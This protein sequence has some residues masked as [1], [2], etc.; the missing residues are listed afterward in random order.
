MKKHLFFLFA[1]LVL[2]M[3]PGAMKAQTTVTIGDGTETTYMAPYYSLYNYSFV[4]QIYTAAEID[5]PTGGLIS[6]IGFYMTSLDNQPITMTVFMKNVSRST[7]DSDMDY[8][9]VDDAVVVYEGSYTFVP[10]WNIIELSTP[11]QYNGT[12]NLMIAFDEH[13]SW[14]SRYFT[15]T[16]VPDAVLCYRSDSEDPDPDDLASFSGSKSVSGGRP[17]L[18]ITFAPNPIVQIGSG[19]QTSVNLPTNVNFNYSLTEQIYMEE[20][21]GQAGDIYTIAF[22]NTT[23]IT[24]RNLNIYMILTNE[25][26]FNSGS[27][28]SAVPSGSLVYSGDVTFLSDTW[29]TIELNTP[30]HY[31]GSGNIMV[32]VDDNTGDEDYALY[33]KVFDATAPRAWYIFNDNTNYSPTSSGSGWRTTMNQKNQIRFGFTPVAC[34][35][36]THLAVS[37]IG[38]N[39]AGVSWEQP[40]SGNQWIVQCSTS[41]D[42]SAFSEVTIGS[43]SWYIYGLNPNTTY[44]VRVAN[45][46]GPEGIS[47]WSSMVSFSTTESPCIA[48]TDLTVSNISYDGAYLTWDQPDGGAEWLI[49][50]STDPEFSSSSFESTFD[51]YLSLTGLAPITTY[52]VRVA[53]DCGTMGISGWVTTSF[54]TTGGAIVVSDIIDFETNNLSQ[55]PFDNDATYPWIVVAVT[56]EC[57]NCG[58]YCMRS[59]NAGWPG[60]SSTIEATHTFDFDGYISFD[61]KCMGEGTSTFYDYCDFLVDDYLVIHHATWLLCGKNQVYSQTSANS[62]SANQLCHKFGLLRFKLCKFIGNNEKMLKRFGHGSLSVQFLIFV[63]IN[64]AYTDFFTCIGKN[65]LSAFQLAFNR[66]TR[67]LDFRSVEV[68]NDSGCMRKMFKRLS[69]TAAFIVNEDKSNLIRMIID[70]ER[71]NICYNKLGFSRT[72]HSRYKAVRPMELLMKIKL[73]RFAKCIDTNGCFQ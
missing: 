46:C 31:S 33:F 49:E 18:Q 43:S 9:P 70:G 5:K 38:S 17:N 13:H 4:E 67:S 15:Y 37:N 47:S 25:T 39:G 10:G 72:C 65:S 50:Y 52:Y 62:G 29:T 19:N 69:H 23:Y 24:T 51:T 35:A 66:Y 12:D 32:V 41:P 58:S 2:M 42:F 7:F 48:P 60:T 8:E 3:A 40:G 64:V 73:K 71:K 53:N 59:G 56:D 1:A 44:Y 6:S 61:A 36:P 30:F 68:G 11:F 54:T 26:T 20:E 63:D 21:I 57:N 34:P 45:S 27:G 14:S 22:Y 28:W 55:Y 16:Q